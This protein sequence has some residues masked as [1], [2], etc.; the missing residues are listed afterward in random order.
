MERDGGRERGRETRGGVCGHGGRVV[1]GGMTSGTTSPFVTFNSTVSGVRG[2]VLA[3]GGG[4]G[5]ADSQGPFPAREFSLPRGVTSGRAPAPPTLAPDDHDQSLWH[6]QP[7]ARAKPKQASRG[8]RASD[9]APSAFACLSL[10]GLGI[11]RRPA[12]PSPPLQHPSPYPRAKEPVF[13]CRAGKFADSGSS[14][15][16]IHPTNSAQPKPAI[17][18]SIEPLMFAL[19]L[20]CGDRRQP[21]KTLI[22][23]GLPFSF[24]AFSF[25]FSIQAHAD[26]NRFPFLG[27]PWYFSGSDAIYPSF[28][29]FLS[30]R[31]IYY[32]LLVVF[33]FPPTLSSLPWHTPT[34]STPHY[35]V[36]S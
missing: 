15:N 33:S 13:S 2:P 34:T 36:M 16:S 32:I 7:T 11:P 4:L 31:R 12:E 24:P 22:P 14:H 9:T 25:H 20:H 10:S 1:V 30:L 26:L 17:P 19:S 28:V 6:H 23:A 29:L 27:F 18:A 35:I 8:R 3:R 21:H 5:V